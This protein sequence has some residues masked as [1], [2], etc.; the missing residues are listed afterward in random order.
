[1][2]PYSA[3]NAT[4][5]AMDPALKAVKFVLRKIRPSNQTKI[6]DAH[7]DAARKT[8]ERNLKLLDHDEAKRLLDQFRR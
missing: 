1:M 7:I 5:Q 6:G 3:Y 2:D 4:S 8:F